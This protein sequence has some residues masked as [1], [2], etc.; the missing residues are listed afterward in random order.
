MHTQKT[1]NIQKKPQNRKNERGNVLFYIL[2]AI[3]LLATLSYAVTQSSR[4][5]SSGVTKERA[6]LFAGEIIA[7]SNAVASATAQL[8]LRGCTPEQISFENNITALYANGSAPA[9]NSCNIF[10]PSGG[11]LSFQNPDKKTKVNGAT[12]LYI[13]GS[14]EIQNIGTTCGTIACSDLTLYIR[15]IREDICIALNNKLGINNPSGVPPVDDGSDF[16]PF[17][18]TFTYDETLGDVAGSAA[19]AGANAGCVRE[20]VAGN[21][22]YYRVLIAR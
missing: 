10:H 20:T 13:D 17:T 15:D 2:I 21:Y 6:N 5:G 18:G 1:L 12:G 19:I 9:D 3:S 22:S 8:R 4:G 16:D 14:M 7:Y 11:G